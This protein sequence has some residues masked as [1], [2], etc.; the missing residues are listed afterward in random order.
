MAIYSAAFLGLVL[1]F[2][3][4]HEIVGA[5]AAKYQW[6]VR[7]AAS[8]S[9]Y[10]IVSGVRIFFVFISALSIWQGALFIERLANECKIKRKG[11]GLS[12]EEKKKIKADYQKR[13]KLLMFSIIFINLGILAVVK[14]F[15]PVAGIGIALPIGISF[16]TFQAIA[17]MVDIYGEKYDAQHSFLR[18]LLYLMWFP[19]L[20]QGP[21]NRYDAI[22]EDLYKQ[23]RLSMSV[24]RYAVYLFLFGAI[25]RYL[26]GD[27]LDPMV[28]NILSG[29]ISV[30]PGSYLLFGAFLYAIE[31]Y[32]NF[33]GGIDMVMAV[34]MLFGVKMAENFKQP[35]FSKSLAQFWRR[36]H[37]SLGAFMRDYVFYP[38]AMT[39]TM[40]NF[41][42]KAGNKWGNHF[43]RSV[44]GGLGNLIVF[45]LV[46][47]WHGPQLHFLAWGLYNGVII[48]I[49]DACSPLF[50]RMKKALKIKDDSRLFTLFQMLRTFMIIV[51]AG[52]F[53]VVDSVRNGVRCF[54]KTFFDFGISE[55]S[56][57]LATDM[58]NNLLDMRM[59][60][61]VIVGIV[62]LLIFSILRENKKDPIALICERHFALRWV[63]FYIMFFAFLISFSMAGGAGG[64][65]YAAF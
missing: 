32:A 63:I 25:K 47:I 28:N 38:F 3:I 11:E 18:I 24:L 60:I 7:L 22:K 6:L 53:D 50:D 5:F 43:A 61:A 46:G 64:F 34:S 65:M 58:E 26:I 12:K 21:I 44:T 27:L 17:Y 55:F 23:T 14:Y 62:L 48:A 30:F 16:Y 52:Y 19:Q 41:T 49:S 56:N 2:I 57:C 33:S 15:L 51:F 39:K 1:L 10:L 42:K 36:W 9:F 59:I 54:I 37:I 35:Y 4:I 29:D 31:Q 8:V 45:A 40:Q 13:K 20:I